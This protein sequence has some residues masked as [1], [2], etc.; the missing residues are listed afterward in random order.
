LVAPTAPGPWSRDE[1]AN[2]EEAKES[3]EAEAFDCKYQL[4]LGGGGG[5]LFAENFPNMLRVESR[6]LSFVCDSIVLG[7]AL[8][9]LLVGGELVVVADDEHEG[10][11]RRRRKQKVNRP[12]Q[13][14]TSFQIWSIKMKFR[15]A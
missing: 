8:Y 10:G 6:V 2:D 5:G 4:S 15:S 9:S 13:S 1:L 12:K 11:R 14:R 7:E 3:I